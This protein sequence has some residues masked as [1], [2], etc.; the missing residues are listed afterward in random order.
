MQEIDY[1][2]FFNDI[3][4]FHA[5]ILLRGSK[6][7][8]RHT[9]NEWRAMGF[10]KHS[11]YADPL[12]VNADERDYRVKPNSPALSLGFNNF[13]VSSAGLLPDFPEQWK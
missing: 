10:D 4:E 1:N 11:V 13:D 5:T 6:I 7:A 2:V 9:L 12:F 3:G 8:V